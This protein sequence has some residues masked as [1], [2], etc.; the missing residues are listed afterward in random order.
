[1]LS[2]DDDP[3]I[4]MHDYER[5][6]DENDVFGIAHM[7]TENYDE[8][9]TRLEG[10]PAAMSNILS[11]RLTQNYRKAPDHPH[12]FTKGMN[13]QTV[14][15]TGEAPLRPGQRHVTPEEGAYYAAP[16]DPERFEASATFQGRKEG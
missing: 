12:T 6:D 5:T 2:P 16:D 10:T 11:D 15:L 7:V 4:V 9:G 14:P 3:Q 8:D 1:M 13:D